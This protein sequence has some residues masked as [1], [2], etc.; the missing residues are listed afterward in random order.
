MIRIVLY[1]QYVL[2]ILYYNT[3]N[4]FPCYIIV[5]VSICKSIKHTKDILQKNNP[6]NLD[7]K[8][9]KVYVKEVYQS[10]NQNSVA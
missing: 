2:Y 4:M 10:L 5:Y 1:I 6:K 3:N 8:N 7:L 9:L